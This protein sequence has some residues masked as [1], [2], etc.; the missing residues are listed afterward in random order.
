MAAYN[1]NDPA[2]VFKN[3]LG[4][5]HLATGSLTFYAI[6]TTT[7][8]DTWNDPD[9]APAHLNANPLN[10]DSSGRPAV[11]IFMDGE[12]TVKLTD[13]A[14][15]TGSTIWTRDVVPGVDAGLSIPALVNGEFLTNDGATLQW[16]AI[17]QVPDPTGQSGKALTSTGA[18]TTWTA[19]PSAPTLDVVIGASSIRIGDG[20]AFPNPK[21]LIQR[22]TGTAP[23]TGNKD[24]SVAVTWATPLASIWHVAITTTITSATPSGALVDNSVTGWTQGSPSTGVTVNFNVS[25]DD[26]NAAWKISNPITFSYLVI[27]TVTG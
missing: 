1:F 23:A 11:D 26:N 4:T 19:F 9:M 25:D 13:G 3:I 16:D 18:G 6:G 27:G 12:Y 21:V 10:L 20:S 15:G 14:G 24:T 5:A 8:K 17:R 2:P 7:P 22:G